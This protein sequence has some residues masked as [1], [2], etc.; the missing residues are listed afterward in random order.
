MIHSFRIETYVEPTAEHLEILEGLGVVI[1]EEAL[2]SWT[3]FQAPIEV[4]AKIPF[5]VKLI[6]GEV[7]VSQF[8]ALHWK[9]TSL[10][11]ALQTLIEKSSESPKNSETFNKKCQ[12]HLPGI[13]LLAINDV[14]LLEDC[15]TD[16]LQKH[17]EDGWRIIAACPQTNQRRPDYI[18]GKSL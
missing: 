7:S 1:P 11:K 13:G 16:A 4:I 17:L 2:Y 5:S 14:K 10:E 8:V 6:P 9:L 15:C 3:E 12:V 18:L